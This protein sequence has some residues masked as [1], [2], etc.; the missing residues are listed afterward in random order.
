M[1]FWPTVSHDRPS[2]AAQAGPTDLVK[3]CNTAWTHAVTALMAVQWRGSPQLGG[4]FRATRYALWALASC[5]TAAGQRDGWWASPEKR[6][7]IEGA[8]VAVADS[9]GRW[10][11]RPLVGGGPRGFLR[12]RGGGGSLRGGCNRREV[13]CGWSS[14][15]L[16]GQ[17]W[18][19]LLMRR[20]RRFSGRWR[21][22]VRQGGGG[23]SR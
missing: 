22:I 17:R 4:G 7:L 11:R 20:W 5:S 13:G 10:G 1:S 19:R 21:W 14:P 15:K 3:W 18:W 9:F 6:V 12:H 23:V 8:E 2:P 16:G